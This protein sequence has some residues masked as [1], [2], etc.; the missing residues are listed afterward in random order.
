LAG[1]IRAVTGEKPKAEAKIQQMLEQ[2]KIGYVPPYNLALVFAGLRETET[3][4]HWLE[5][6]LADRD[7]HMTFLLDHK[8]EELPL[9]QKRVSVQN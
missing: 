2:K 5:Q 7:V 4:L 1:Y 3:A 8:W 9:V 6:A